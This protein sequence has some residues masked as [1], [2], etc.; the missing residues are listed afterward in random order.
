MLLEAAL[1]FYLP[2]LGAGA[3]V[4]GSEQKRAEEDVP[5]FTRRDIS[6]TE[7]PQEGL[8]QLLHNPNPDHLNSPVRAR[9][10]AQN[11]LNKRGGVGNETA[12]TIFSGVY[13]VI[14][15]TWG[16]QD[17]QTPGQQFISFIDTGSSDTWAMSSDFQCVDIATKVPLN[18]ADCGFGNTYDLSAGSFTNITSEK[19]GISYFPEDEVLRGDMGYAPIS[20]GGL[21]VPQQEVALVNYAA[22]VGDGYTSG[23]VGL[24]YPAITSATN[25]TTG[26]SIQYN[27]LFTNMAE[28][29]I[30]TDAIF[31]LAVDRVPQGTSPLEP[32]GLMAV[33]GLVPES[34]YEP[35]F[36]SVPIQSELGV[37]TWYTIKHS[38]KYG[39]NSTSTVSTNTYE[40]IVDSGTAPNFIPTSAAVKLN[41]LFD[42][43]A[44][45]NA[46]L[47]Y[48]VTECDATPPYA[49]Y[50][51]DGVEM[52]MP[53]D[54]LIVRS[55]NGLPGYEDVCFSAFADGGIQ[56]PGS[57]NFIIGAVWQWSYVVAYD[58]K[59]SLM[60]FA[61][62]TPY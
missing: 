33:G 49:A 25:R 3:V 21:T 32:A 54:D 8:I 6:I 52:P 11:R 51:I 17:T 56:T 43:P 34:Y 61:K 9:I 42:P 20:M 7:A 45:Y 48:W 22:W 47:G 59:N 1:V 55:L 28:Q 38:F 24:G 23:L 60:H 44:V 30:V 40:S 18:Q 15:I 31:T 13:P 12:N 4:P 37:K 62:R 53:A 58:Q 16:N 39:K 5:R 10:A 27:P 50:V 35:P 41:A 46:T 29:D 19:F 14:N 2:L 57:T 36:T 26:R